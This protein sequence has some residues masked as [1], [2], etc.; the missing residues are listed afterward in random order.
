MQQSFQLKLLCKETKA[1]TCIFLVCMF[2]SCSIDHQISVSFQARTLFSWFYVTRSNFCTEE[3]DLR[4]RGVHG[5]GGSLAVLFVMWSYGG[6]TVLKFD[7]SSADC[8]NPSNQSGVRVGQTLA[9]CPCL[10]FGERALS[11]VSKLQPSF[12]PVQVT[13]LQW[14]HAVVIY[15]SA[16]GQCSQ[17]TMS[18]LIWRYTINRQLT[19]VGDG[20][21][22]QLRF[23]CHRL[24]WF[25]TETTTVCQLRRKLQSSDR[26][27][28]RQR[29]PL[30]AVDGLRTLFTY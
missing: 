25:A 11:V 3:A 5:I 30:A 6:A 18:T 28:D 24:K 13:S 21:R 27:P 15:M 14:P 8:R 4:R 23:V 29:A 26:P 9:R 19:S 12:R 7:D 2:F 22:S 20:R 16:T 1:L 17:W 10:P